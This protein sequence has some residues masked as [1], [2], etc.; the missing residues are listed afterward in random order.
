MDKKLR[1]LTAWDLT[2]IEKALELAVGAGVIERRTTEDLR[3]A[4]AEATS[5]TLVKEGHGNVF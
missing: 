3:A 4:I 5:G 2:A 1:T